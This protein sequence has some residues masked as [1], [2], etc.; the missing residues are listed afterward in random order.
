M[1]NTENQTKKEDILKT[2]SEYGIKEGTLRK[3][4]DYKIISNALITKYESLIWANVELSGTKIKVFL[5]PRTPTPQIVPF[6]VPA[7]VIAKKDGVIT[8]IVAENGEKRVKT[9]DTVIKG[10]VLISGIIPSPVVGT[11]YV[12]SQGKIIAKTWTEK[13]KEQKLYRYDKEFTGNKIKKS[14]I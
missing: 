9:G 3:N 4:F 12:H 1:S 6:G 8:E 10:Q 5:V 7:D 13:E 2:L 11:R 14:E